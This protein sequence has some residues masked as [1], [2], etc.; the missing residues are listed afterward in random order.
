MLPSAKLETVAQIGGFACEAAHDDDFAPVLLS[1]FESL[2]DAEG[3]VFYDMSGPFARPSFGK[4]VYRNIERAYGE[5]YGEH[6]NK[7]D[8]CFNSLAPEHGAGYLAT[9]S[10]L[11]AVNELPS[12]VE[13]EYYQD[14]LKPQGIHTSIIFTVSDD[15]GLL[16]LFGFQRPLHR[17]GF[18]DYAHL[19]VRLSAAPIAQALDKRRKEGPGSSGAGGLSVKVGGIELT[20]RQLEIA[21]LVTLGLTNNEIA[22]QLSIS[23]KTVE[24]HLTRIYELAGSANRVTLAQTLTVLLSNA[25]NR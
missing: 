20:A 14:F 17:D 10:T 15:A 13:S 11:R 16:G 7:L 6:Y 18:D 9:A 1:K 19:L 25:S 4:S 5:M 12:Y 24:N 8:P 3:A 22:R 21:K 23:T 2:L